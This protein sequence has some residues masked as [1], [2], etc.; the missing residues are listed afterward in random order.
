MTKQPLRL[1]ILGAL[2]LQPMTNGQLQRVLSASE[3]G[4]RA[5]LRRLKAS[6]EVQAQGRP[7]VYRLKSHSTEGKQ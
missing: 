4:I 1:R 5:Q 3:A 2:A 7:Y 6:G